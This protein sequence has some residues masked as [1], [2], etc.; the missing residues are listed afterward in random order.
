M[1]LILIGFFESNISI[2]EL[3]INVLF[4]FDKLSYMP[5]YRIVKC[6]LCGLVYSN[7]VLRDEIINRLYCKQMERYSTLELPQV[8]KSMRGYYKSFQSF[9]TS[10][11]T[12]LDIGC[13]DGVLLKILKENNFKNLFGIEPSFGDTKDGSVQIKDV[14]VLTDV[15][16]KEQFQQGFFDLITIIHVLDHIKAPNEFL[17]NIR[18]HLKENGI[19]Y[20]VVHSYDS[21]MSR[22]LKD[23]FH[24]INVQH[25]DFF[26]KSTLGMIMENNGL[27]V[28]KI[29]NTFNVYTLSGYLERSP[30]KGNKLLNKLLEIFTLD[31]IPLKLPLG[32]IAVICKPN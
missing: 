28:I 24:P 17:K 9:L 30:L 1:Y 5:H 2:N 27:Q 10:Y 11:D 29:L 6:E 12:A 16:K 23:K 25:I 26:T 7:P 21:L 3:D 32:N 19:L 13:Y 14:H 31:R 15:Y 18:F 20:C 4:D 22:L 8:E